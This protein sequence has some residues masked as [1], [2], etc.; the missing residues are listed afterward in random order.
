M[1]P[2]LK[3][4]FLVTLSLAGLLLLNSP[5]SAHDDWQYERFRNELGEVH[6]GDHDDL[7]ALHQEFHEHPYSKRE[8]RRFHRWFKERSPRCLGPQDCGPVPS[9]QRDKESGAVPRCLGPQDCGPV[10]SPR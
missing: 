1:R 10:P 4:P 2:K 7:N 8:H 6:Q 9:R 3:K 5:A